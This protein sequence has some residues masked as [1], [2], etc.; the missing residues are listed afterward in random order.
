MD[1]VIN[2]LKHL[3]NCAMSQSAG[4]PIDSYVINEVWTRFLESMDGTI[5][6]IKPTEMYRSTLHED[7]K[8]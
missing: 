2:T 6:V 3:F 7:D 8:K 4:K 1:E 5:D